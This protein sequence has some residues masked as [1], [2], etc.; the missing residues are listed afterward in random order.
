MSFKKDLVKHL[1]SRG[2]SI[3]ADAALD[4][5]SMVCTFTAEV[6]EMKEPGAFR[7]IAALKSAAMSIDLELNEEE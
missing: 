2:W 6:M 3:K 1:E 4:L 7:D 5:A